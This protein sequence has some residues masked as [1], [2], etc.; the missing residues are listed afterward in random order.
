[1]KLFTRKELKLDVQAEAETIREKEAVVIKSLNEKLALL[2]G[3]E[4]QYKDKLEQKRI[5]LAEAES[6]LKIFLANK[7]KE[8]IILEERRKQAL[9]PIVEELS[10]LEATKKE[11]EAFILSLDEKQDELKRAEAQLRKKENEIQQAES[12]VAVLK[13]ETIAVIESQKKEAEALI[14]QAKTAVSSLEKEEERALK[15][16]KRA[17]E[18]R[19]SAERAENIAKGAMV[20]ADQ[21]IAQEKV[22]QAKTDDK[23]KMLR[24]ALEYA[25]KKNV[26]LPPEITTK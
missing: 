12:K 20:A 17:E 14:A 5:E 6:K 22:E 2:N 16:I 23:R 7:E 8:V 13:E 10:K 1:M 4:G 11:I 18:R 25:K 24:T 21:R 3:V 15:V 9:T 19:A 26:C